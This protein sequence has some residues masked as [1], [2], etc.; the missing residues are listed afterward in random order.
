MT[1]NEAGH[2]TIGRSYNYLPTSSELKRV[3]TGILMTH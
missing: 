3:W 2:L 1:E